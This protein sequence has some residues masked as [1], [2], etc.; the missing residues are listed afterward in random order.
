LQA[1]PGVT[2][3]SIDHLRKLT[4]LKTLAIG[5]TGISDEGTAKLAAA[6]PQ[7]KIVRD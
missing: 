3:A 7:C 6:L 4:G 5:Q 1:D 2:D